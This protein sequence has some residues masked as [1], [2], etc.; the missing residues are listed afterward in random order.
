MKTN[1][2]RAF[3]LVELLIVIAIIGALV[4]LLLPAINAAR[5]TARRTQCINNQKQIATAI[6]SSIGSKSYPGWVQAQK[7]QVDTGNPPPNGI[8]PDYNNA[9]VGQLAISW[10]GKIL[11]EMDQGAMWESMLTGRMDLNQVPRQDVYLCPS[12][13]RLNEELAHL[14][15]VA[16]AGAPDVNDDPSD[17]AANGLFHNLLP[18][19]NG[20]KVSNIKD[21]A[22]TTLLIS[23]NTHKDDR[24]DSSWLMTSDWYQN[25]IVPATGE[26]RYGMVWVY[27]ASSPERPNIQ[28]ALNRDLGG[29]SGG[30]Y[31]ADGFRYA[32]PAGVHGDTFV[33]A[34]AGGN[35]R[36]I[37]QDIEYRVYQ[38]LMTPNGAKCVWT[39]EP[40]VNLDQAAPAFRNIGKQLSDSDF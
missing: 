24:E 2:R 30:F 27:D 28:E 6:I 14:S 8:Y 34:M 38:Q 37:S 32:R 16:N 36:E 4:G 20:P 9:G 5:A 1:R 19:M 15:Y 29:P 31:E 17:Y 40:S 25:G 35:V 7:F 10:A 18:G 23:E 39:L 21:G 11:P 33:A 22:Q 12:D 13:V 26:Q 3:T